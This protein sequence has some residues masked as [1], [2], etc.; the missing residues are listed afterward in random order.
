MDDKRIEM[1]GDEP[2]PPELLDEIREGYRPP[3]P[4][5]REAIWAEIMEG[6]ERGGAGRRLRRWESRPPLLRVAAGV[7]LLLGGVALGRVTAPEGGEG[8]PQPMT[9]EVPEA[10]LEPGAGGDAG[11]ILPTFAHLREADVLLDML[12]EDG[13]EVEVREQIARWAEFL[14]V[15]TRI[16]RELHGHGGSNLA[17]LLSDVE[18]TLLEVATLDD[19]GGV[20]S[21][22]DPVRLI[23]RSVEERGLR[24]RIQA[25]L[26]GVA[27]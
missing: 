9:A 15:E 27:H 14:L 24:T 13:V 10:Y 3:A 16:L 25:A 23:A 11:P 26:P 18:T 4:P 1:G 5:P 22:G 21:S 12:M 6:V 7:V 2:L 8:P 19:R 20:G 17:I